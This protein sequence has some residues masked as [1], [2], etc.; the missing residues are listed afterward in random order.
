[1]GLSKEQLSM[2]TELKKQADAF[3]RFRNELPY[4]IVTLWSKLV[5]HL[6]EYYYLD[7]Q[8]DG[9][10]LVLCSDGHAKGEVLIRMKL[11][12]DKISFSFEDEA[13]P[14]VL[15][16]SDSEGD[17]IERLKAKNL[18]KRI[19]PNENIVVSAGKGR[20]DLCLHSKMSL[21]KQDRRV[22]MSM[23]LAKC[24]GWVFDMT[25]DECSGSSPDCRI[26]DIGI[27]TPGMTADEVTHILF[28][29]WWT[30]SRRFLEDK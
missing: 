26:D 13:E 7:E 30:K 21:A 25:A 10:E 18:P 22:E 17:V 8:W 27:A 15:T 23:G 14:V 20:C 9:N 28:P 29:Y 16:M 19:L 2:L 5:G 12:A 11:A 24:Y 4:G 1:M 6:R 3:E